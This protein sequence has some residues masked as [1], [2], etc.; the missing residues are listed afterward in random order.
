MHPEKRISN[1]KRRQEIE[2]K[3]LK[4]ESKY[5]D[6]NGRVFDL[7]KL[8]DTHF[9]ALKDEIKNNGNGGK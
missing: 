4:N 3:Y 6:E 2:K 9:V 1:K 5:Y 7:K 8:T